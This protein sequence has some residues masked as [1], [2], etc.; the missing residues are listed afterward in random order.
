MQSLM[1]SLFEEL[2]KPANLIF[3]HNLQSNLESA[4]RASNAQYNDPECLKKLYIKLINASVGDIGWDIFCLEYKVDLP[5]SVIF[6]SKLLKD[7]QKLFFFFWKIKRIEYSQNNHVWKKIKTFSQFLKNK[8]DYMKKPIEISIHFNQEIIHFITNLHNYLALEVLETQYKKLI[9]DLPKVN[10]LDELINKHKQFVDNIKKQCLL[11]EENNPI[12]KKINNIFDIILRFR[13]IHDVLYNFLVEN[14][15]ENSN[16]ISGNNYINQNRHKNIKEYLQQISILYKDFQNQI[17]ELINTINLLGKDNLKYLNVKLDFNYYYSFLEKEEEEKKN[18]EAIRRINAEEE[19]R[20]IIEGKISDDDND[21]DISN[22][23]NYSHNLGNK[24]GNNNTDNDYI[25]NEKEEAENAG[26]EEMEIDENNNINTRNYRFQNL[27]NNDQSLQESNNNS[28]IINDFDNNNNLEVS[29]DSN[30]NNNM[31]NNFDKK[32]FLENSNNIFGKSSKYYS[33][34]N[35]NSN[36]DINNNLKSNI[37]DDKDINNITG[38]KTSKNNNIQ[39]ITKRK[40][41]KPR[42][43]NIDS[44]NVL[45]INKYYVNNNLNDGNDNAIDNNNNNDYKIN[46]YMIKTQIVPKTYQY[47]K[48]NMQSGLTYDFKT[49]TKT[50]PITNNLENVDDEDKITTDIKPKKY[51]I[52]TRARAKKDDDNK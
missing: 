8:L 9:N 16:D 37:D 25:G 51:E 14:S 42:E 38:F 40:D 34:K 52:T 48:N 26:N 35:D 20:K 4:I 49:M 2:N 5:L 45:D 22:N 44:N 39:I 27:E 10:N 50:K 46:N 31:N 17:I 30:K 47:E 15:Y 11:G 7:Y 3:K 18:L 28:N 1:E 29:N 21:N 12:N 33:S 19:R 13:T 6:N 36:N 23:N 24:Y 41:N 43:N 32:N